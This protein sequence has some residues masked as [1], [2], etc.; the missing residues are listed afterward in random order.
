[1]KTKSLKRSLGSMALAF[2]SFVVFFAMLAA[3]GLQLA[4]GVT[5]WV[6]GLSI[7]I[8]MI[9]LP[10]VLGKK[11]SYAIGWALQVLV[12]GISI[13]TI[14]F[15]PLGYGYLVFSLIFIGVWAWA[16]IAGSTVD[17]ANRVLENQSNEENGN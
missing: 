5:V 13:F 11:G 8:V 10:G 7:S 16:M 14:A 1:M 4:D 15:S 3:F 12:L 6:I 9:L 2:E 17:A